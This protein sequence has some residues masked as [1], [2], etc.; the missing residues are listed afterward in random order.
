M[1]YRWSSQDD[2]ETSVVPVCVSE[3][4]PGV[5]RQGEKHLFYHTDES[6]LKAVLESEEEPAFR[7]D[8]SFG[9]AGITL[10]ELSHYGL[11]VDTAGYDTKYMFV[12]RAITVVDTLIYDPDP[13]GEQAGRTYRK[14][15]LSQ[16][17][18]EFL[19][20]YKVWIPQNDYD[21]G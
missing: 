10:D 12:V 9:M 5:L 21:L 8:A 14:S 3:F 16:V 1:A 19:I 17:L 15:N 11:G 7:R 20:S 13:E 4:E 6:E 18:P 2:T